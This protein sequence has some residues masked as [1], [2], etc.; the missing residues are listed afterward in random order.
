MA[1]L[2]S[3]MEVLNC[4]VSNFIRDIQQNVVWSVSKTSFMNGNLFIYN[5][6]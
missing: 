5:G 1:I 3:F 2:D 6:H 4:S